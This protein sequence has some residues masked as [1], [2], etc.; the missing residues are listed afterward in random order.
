VYINMSSQG[1]LFTHMVYQSRKKRPD[2]IW[3]TW[4]LNSRR[5]GGGGSSDRGF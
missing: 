5:G 3:P 1:K 2:E 4:E